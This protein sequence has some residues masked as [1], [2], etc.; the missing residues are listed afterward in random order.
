MLLAFLLEALII[1]VIGGIVGLTLTFVGTYLL[2]INGIPF[3][4]GSNNGSNL[5]IVIRPLFSMSDVGISIVIALVAS[6]IAGIYPAWKASKLTV[7]EAVR[8]D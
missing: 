7:I 4:A 8:K 1:G 6:V 2:D 3:N 5:L